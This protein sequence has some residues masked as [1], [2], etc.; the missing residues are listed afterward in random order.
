MIRNLPISQMEFNF[1]LRRPIS[2]WP[3]G[4]IM[5]KKDELLT[6]IV[7]YDPDISHRAPNTHPNNSGPQK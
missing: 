1:I 4:E 2:I 5:S 6:S 3:N 7:A